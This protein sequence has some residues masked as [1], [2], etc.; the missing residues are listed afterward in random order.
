MADIH[1]ITQDK[2]ITDFVFPSKLTNILSA[3]G[4]SI[5]SA[6]TNTQLA[7][8]VKKYNIGYIINTWIPRLNYLMQL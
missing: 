2:N 8:L 7:Q 5:I 1:L 4:V 3:G 6:K